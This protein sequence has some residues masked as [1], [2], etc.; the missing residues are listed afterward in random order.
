[1]RPSRNAPAPRRRPLRALAGVA[2][3]LALSLTLPATAAR[4]EPPAAAPD[5][6][7]GELVQAWPEAGLAGSAAEAEHAAAPLTWVETPAGDAVRV[8]TEAVGGREV[9]APREVTVGA[10]LAH[11]ARPAG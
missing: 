10:H 3:A 9:G 4:A 11:P 2:T 8:P 6:V 5:T 1:M 7:V